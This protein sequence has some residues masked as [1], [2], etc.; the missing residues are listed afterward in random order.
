MTNP[1]LDVTRIEPRFK[2]ATIFQTFDGLDVGESFVLRNDHDPV[3]LRYQ[4]QA[5]RPDAFG[6]EYLEQGPATWRVRLTKLS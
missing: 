1:E 4:F 6:W 5:E 3:P 2:H